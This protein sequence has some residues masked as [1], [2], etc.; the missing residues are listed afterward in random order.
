[1]VVAH[2]RA[3][4]RPHTRP[5][6]SLSPLV[7]RRPR[8]RSWICGRDHR[9]ST[10]HRSTRSRK[11]QQQKD[12]GAKRAPPTKEERRLCSRAPRSRVRLAR[13]HPIFAN[14]PDAPQGGD[15]TTVMTTDP[16]PRAVASA[17]RL[18][19]RARRDG[20]DGAGRRLG[21]GRAS[22]AGHVC[23]GA[24]SSHGAADSP[25][26]LRMKSSRRRW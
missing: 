22:L 15:P 3:I 11:Q 14:A 16:P 2:R 17:R 20:Q 9:R 19:R 21:G 6:P 1:M 25:V 5:E 12:R 8:R 23:G 18:N 7:R 26:G 13:P 10:S 24:G 4:E